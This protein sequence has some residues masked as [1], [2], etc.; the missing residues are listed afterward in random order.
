MPP[1]NSLRQTVTPSSSWLHV[2]N[3]A[4]PGRH[5]NVAEESRLANGKEQHVHRK[6]VLLCHSESLILVST[7][8]GGGGKMW[9]GGVGERIVGKVAVCFR[10]GKIFPWREEPQEVLCLYASHCARVLHSQAPLRISLSFIFFFI[11]LFFGERETFF[12]Q[13]TIPYIPFTL[14]VFSSLF[15]RDQY[16]NLNRNPISLSYVRILI[17]I[18][19]ICSFTAIGFP[20]RGCRR[21]TCIK[22]GKRQHQKEKQ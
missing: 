19:E 20:P 3:F 8:K 5:L 12:L 2:T 16:L 21:S 6:R 11:S 4:Q 10:C 15:H 13:V 18:C 7:L 9:G 17:L 22:M 14:N 1:I